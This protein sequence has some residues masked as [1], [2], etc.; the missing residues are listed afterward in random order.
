M[1]ADDLPRTYDELDAW[2]RANPGRFTYIAP[3]PGAFQGTRFVKQM[4]YYVSGGYEQWVG[5]WNQELYDQH[6]PVPSDRSSHK[7]ISESVS[8]WIPS[9]FSI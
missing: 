9:S 4:L 6:S 2:I 3:G 1:N 5:E 7:A 8:I